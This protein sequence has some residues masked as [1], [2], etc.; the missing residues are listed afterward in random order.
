MLKE[1]VL[2]GAYQ[3]VCREDCGHDFMIPLFQK[4]LHKEI[5]F[6]VSSVRRSGDRANDISFDALMGGRLHVG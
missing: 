1:W 3:T 6:I 5:S 2:L 4:P